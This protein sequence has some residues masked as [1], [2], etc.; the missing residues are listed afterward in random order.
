MHT[1]GPQVSEVSCHQLLEASSYA[2]LSVILYDC[3]NNFNYLANSPGKNSILQGYRNHNLLSTCLYK[4]DL[5]KLSISMKI[6][7]GK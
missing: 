7:F 2:A 1:E 4:G 6:N 5:L 3:A